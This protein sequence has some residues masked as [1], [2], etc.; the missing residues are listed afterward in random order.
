VVEAVAEFL[1]A[2]KKID[3]TI[4]PPP[5]PAPAPTVDN[6]AGDDGEAPPPSDGSGGSDSGGSD[7]S[8]PPSAMKSRGAVYEH[9][10]GYYYTIRKVKDDWVEER[11][12]NF[13]LI[14]TKF[15][16]LQGGGRRFCCDIKCING[17]TEKEVIFDRA[18]QSAKYFKNEI[19][20]RSNE[21]AWHGTDTNVSS[22][23]ELML[24]SPL[25]EYMG[26]SSL[27][28]VETKSGPRWVM[29]DY[30]LG[31]DGRDNDSRIV[32][33]GPPAASPIADYV[34]LK[35]AELSDDEIR[36]L[37]QRVLP[38]IFT[39]NTPEVILPLIGWF[40]AAPVTPI[41][42]SVLGH[43]SLLW[44][45]GTQG[46][47]KSTLACDIFWPLMGVKSE[48]LTCADTPFA[49]LATMSSTTSISLVYD[50]F[51]DLSQRQKESFLNRLRSI[52][53]GAIEKRG[54]QD[55]TLVFYQV[56]APVCII[57]EQPPSDPAILERSLCVSPYK[58]TVNSKAGREI[59]QLTHEPLQLLGGHYVKFILGRDIREDIKTA[60]AL[61]EAKML[62][63]LADKPSSRICDT[64]LVAVLGDYLHQRW[65]DQIGVTIPDR[66]Q[67][68]DVFKALVGNI[69]ESEDGGPAKDVV[70]MFLESLSTYA[71]L[72]ILRENIHY[73]FVNG[74]LCLHLESCYEV[75]L[76]ERRK[77]GQPDATN[78]IKALRRVLKEKL[79]AG[80]YIV[81]ISHR[82]RLGE[83]ER[84][85]RAVQIDPDKVPEHINAD[86]FPVSGNRRQGGFNQRSFG[87]FN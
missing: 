15:V 58:T 26:V 25:P 13:I 80:G 38:K 30:I 55:Q 73:A 81:N 61:M 19:Q 17:Y 34:D 76:A 18:F 39:L 40:F 67:M 28:Y 65:C 12:S 87:D 31:P 46:C 71:H 37:A 59:A 57:G 14:P 36:A 42:R 33:A 35:G 10:E 7:G 52:Y 74:K 49:M 64:L 24:S 23:N 29:P 11:L 84:Q 32:Y 8:M 43:M 72:G 47:G 2:L 83:D 79:Q 68:R 16:R 56:V 78:G 63:L 45:W 62:P 48:P 4:L 9:P 1:R 27:G 20:S 75:Y 82:V 50:E 51:R 86:R 69:T 77:T 85:V 60:R 21:F 53:K 66:P 44:L 41:I 54:R 6:P 5:H 3:S 70:D 22:V